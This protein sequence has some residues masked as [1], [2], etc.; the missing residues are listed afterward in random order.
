MVTTGI[1]LQQGGSF[2]QL[3]KEQSSWVLISKIGL[4]YIMSD[5]TEFPNIEPEPVHDLSF[6]EVR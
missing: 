4:I 5:N 2:F 3:I 6:K 1:N